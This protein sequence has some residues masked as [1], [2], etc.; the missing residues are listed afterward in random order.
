[1]ASASAFSSSAEAAIQRTVELNDAGT[2][3]ATTPGTA[4]GDIARIYELDDV[5]R[6][7]RDRGFKTIALQFPDELLHDAVPVYREL[8][9]R[10]P[11]DAQ[12]YVLAD[13][14]YGS[15]CVDEVAAQHVD[16]EVVVHFGHACLSRTSR[17]PVLYVFGR[18]ALDAEHAIA[19]LLESCRSPPSH[20]KLL[21]DVAYAHVAETLREAAQ[22]AL[23]NAQI[24][25]SPAP[26]RFQPP[27]PDADAAASPQ[28]SEDAVVFYVG[29]E[30]LALSTVLMTHALTPAYSYDPMTRTARAESARTNGRLA[31]RYALVHRARAADVFGIV[32][33]TLGVAAYLP[34]IGHLRAALARARKKTYTL[35]V[36]KLNPAKLANFPDIGAFVLVA[37]AQTSLVDSRDY[38]APVVTP[39]E[40]LLALAPGEPAWTGDYALDFARLLA[41]PLPAEDEEDAEPQYDFTSGRLR[42]ARRFGADSSTPGPT[43]ALVARSAENALSTVGAGFLRD[44]AFKGLEVNAGRD[45]PSVLEQGRSGIARGYDT[46]AEA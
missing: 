26:A 38:F 20:V 13:T 10:L 41:M 30:S 22:A 4:D 31:R 16:A 15:C 35:A 46:V 18:L 1:M 39:F 37:C 23:P 17:L 21:Y 44:R 42:T 11:D 7:V 25:W 36:G 27:G 34:L 45:A 2:S 28:P 24:Q 6:E 19:T 9:Q 12:A 14:S 5:A 33:G 32:V 8:K 3:L 40:L 43:D 29:A